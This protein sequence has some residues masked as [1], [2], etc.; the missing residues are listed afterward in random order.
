MLERGGRLAIYEPRYAN[1][2]NPHTRVVSAGEQQRVL[3]MAAS[4]RTMTLAPPLARFAGGLP[5]GI[6]ATLAR[7][8]L[9]RTHRLTVYERSSGHGD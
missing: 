8:P 7:I 1:P 2:I 4:S 3:G 5:H 9:L 6:Y